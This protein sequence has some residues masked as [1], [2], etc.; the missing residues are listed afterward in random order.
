[1][2]NDIKPNYYHT[3]GIDVIE[4][5]RLS[6]GQHAAKEFCRGNVIKYVTRYDKKNGVEDLQKAQTYI[7]RL[8]ELEG[9]GV[10]V[11]ET[12]SPPPPGPPPINR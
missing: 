5:I 10:K 11:G 1:M 8:M 4:Y 3:N 12:I 2:T 7:H 9:E 6:Q